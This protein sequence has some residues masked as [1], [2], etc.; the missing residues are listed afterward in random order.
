MNSAICLNEMGAAWVVRSEYASIYTPAFDF[1]SKKHHECVISSQRMGVVLNSDGH[2]KVGMIELKN[3]IIS[4]FGLEVDETTTL[5]LV[6]G[7]VEEIVRQ[8]EKVEK[9]NS[10]TEKVKKRK[11]KDDLIILG[12]NEVAVIQS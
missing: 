3:K 9:L 10:K 6:D 7:F 8:K 5:R 12:V 1:G 11:D 2:C 4:M